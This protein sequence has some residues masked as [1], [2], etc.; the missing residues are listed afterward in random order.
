M[1]VLKVKVISWPWPKV[2][3]I[4]KFKPDF[5]RNYFADLNQIL[6][7]SF[8]VQGNENLMTWCWSHDQDGHHAHIWYKPFKNLPLRNRR[9][10]F[11]VTCNIASGTPAHHSLF[12]WWPWSDLDLFYGKF[13]FGYRFFYGKSEN[14]GFFRSS[15]YSITWEQIDKMR[16]N[17]V[18]SLSLTRSTSMI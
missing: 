3:N 11:Y 15:G 17:F 5:L 16:L 13:K 12:K 1:W 8:E 18:Y 9:A 4:W 2:M 7:E 14:S 10:D 6:Y